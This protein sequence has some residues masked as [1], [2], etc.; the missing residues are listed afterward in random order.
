MLGEEPE[1]AGIPCR[2]PVGTNSVVVAIQSLSAVLQSNRRI[3][4]SGYIEVAVGA[5]GIGDPG[6]SPDDEEE[7]REEEPSRRC[8]G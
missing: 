2:P 7:D 5:A 3:V 4:G 1:A 6:S 8:Q